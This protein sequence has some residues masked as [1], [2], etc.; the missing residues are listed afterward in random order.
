MYSKEI[1]DFIKS[2]NYR[3]HGADILK[4]ISWEN[5]PQISEVKYDDGAKTYF[6]ATN[7]NYQFYFEALPFNNEQ[8]K[9]LTRKIS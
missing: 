2:R 1:E 5:N 6:V 4:V 7:D 9:T 8:N 3:L